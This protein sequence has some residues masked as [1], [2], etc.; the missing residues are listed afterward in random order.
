L[1]RGDDGGQVQ[2][3]RRG[4]KDTFLVIIVSFLSPFFFLFSIF[5]F[6]VVLS[7]SRSQSS[8]D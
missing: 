8:C 3:T 7:L 1:R 6:S 2:F 4:S 5:F